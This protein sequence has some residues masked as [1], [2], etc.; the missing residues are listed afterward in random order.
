MA[1][2]RRVIDWYG[3]N[4]GLDFAVEEDLVGGTAYDIHGVP[5]TDATMARAQE[6]DAVLLGA[7]DR[8]PPPATDRLEETL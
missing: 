8:T 3:A 1:E 4:R 5:L 7:L 2:V 6:V